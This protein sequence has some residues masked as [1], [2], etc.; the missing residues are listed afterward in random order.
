MSRFSKCHTTAAT[1]NRGRMLQYTIVRC[2]QR[3]QQGPVLIWGRK[4]DWRLPGYISQYRWSSSALMGSNMADPS[5]A[6]HETILAS[7]DAQ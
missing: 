1:A 5:M 2:C 6:P 4:G 3:E 7:L